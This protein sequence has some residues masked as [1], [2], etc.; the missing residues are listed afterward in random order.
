MERSIDHHESQS[1]P[2]RTSAGSN[3]VTK[4]RDAWTACFTVLEGYSSTNLKNFHLVFGQWV[5]ILN[6][7]FGNPIRPLRQYVP[8]FYYCKEPNGPKEILHMYM[9]P[10]VGENNEHFIHIF[11]NLYELNK[12]RRD[13]C[14][15]VNRNNPM[16]VDEARGTINFSVLEDTINN[17]AEYF[18]H[19]STWQMLFVHTLHLM[20]HWDTYDKNQHANYDT[21]MQFKDS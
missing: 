6:W 1:P 10:N 2:G 7:I 17:P 18:Q 9:D 3:R 13:Y 14:E 15:N 16:L 12:I 5:S 19:I 20:A 21:H 8:Y 4:W 11:L